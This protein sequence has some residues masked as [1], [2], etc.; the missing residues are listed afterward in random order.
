MGIYQGLT[1]VTTN[2]WIKHAGQADGLQAAAA[3]CADTFN[4]LPGVHM[5]SGQEIYNSVLAGAFAVGVPVA[6][7]WI[8]FPSSNEPAGTPVFNAGQGQAD[9]CGG[10]TYLTADRLW[11]GIAFEWNANANT[12]NYSPFYDTIPCSS[13]IPIAC[14][15]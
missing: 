6:K 2:G 1:A 15:W 12:S 10:Y 13:S 7:G 4:S 3:V 14:C 5:C 8:Y 11:R 9:N